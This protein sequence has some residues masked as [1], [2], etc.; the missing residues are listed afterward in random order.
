MRVRNT[1]A[2]DR[3]VVSSALADEVRGRDDLRVVGPASDWVFDARGDIAPAAD[4]LAGAPAWS[5]LQRHALPGSVA[6]DYHQR[7]RGRF[8]V[9]GSKPCL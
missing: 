5:A 9:E 3:L 7:V 8:R 2:L 6:P 4:L 1:L